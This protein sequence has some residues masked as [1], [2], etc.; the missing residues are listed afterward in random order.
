MSNYAH[1]SGI[2]ESIS[3]SNEITYKCNIIACKTSLFFFFVSL[4]LFDSFISIVFP[5]L[6]LICFSV[7]TVTHVT[8]EGMGGGVDI[9]QKQEPISNRLRSNICLQIPCPQANNSSP[10]RKS[11][12]IMGCTL[13][14]QPSVLPIFCFLVKAITDILRLLL[15]C[16]MSSI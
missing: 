5:S 6:P 8:Y 4:F 7:K 10:M 13:W 15:K 16:K 3:R 14:C 11:L 9:F 1:F 12:A 2:F